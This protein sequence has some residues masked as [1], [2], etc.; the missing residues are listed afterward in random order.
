MVGWSFT[1]TDISA[2]FFF[3]IVWNRKVVVCISSLQRL[4]AMTT[5]HPD[6][7]RV[8]G[9]VEGYSTTWIYHGIR[10]CT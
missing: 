8:L 3:L 6:F 5:Q 4:M 7:A 9:Q 2:V 1:V 10:L